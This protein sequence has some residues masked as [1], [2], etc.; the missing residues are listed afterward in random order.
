MVDIA[1]IK[2]V[3]SFKLIKN[4]GKTSQA[5]KDKLDAI[6]TKEAEQ[7]AKD[8]KKGKIDEKELKKKLDEIKKE[9]IRAELPKLNVNK[10]LKVIK[11]KPEE[12]K[13]QVKQTEKNTE[14]KKKDKP[15]QPKRKAPTLKEVREKNLKEKR[16]A[17]KPKRKP[18]QKKDTV[19]GKPP[20]VEK[21]KLIKYVEKNLDTS[22]SSKQQPKLIQ[23]IIEYFYKEAIDG[24][25]VK[26]NTYRKG[27]NLEFL[28]NYD[29]EAEGYKNIEDFR[30]LYKS[31]IIKNIK[32]NNLDID[33]LEESSN[34]DENEIIKIISSKEEPKKKEQAKQTEK[35]PEPETD[36]EDEDFVLPSFFKNTP[37]DIKKNILK[38]VDKGDLPSS[39]FVL[40][41]VYKTIRKIKNAVEK[42]DRGND[43]RIDGLGRGLSADSEDENY[44]KAIYNKKFPK[45]EI[46]KEFLSVA[47]NMIGGDRDTKMKARKW[48][49]KADVTIQKKLFNFNKEG[50]L[51]TVTGVNDK[52]GE[53]RKEADKVDRA[54]AREKAQREKEFQQAKREQA[55]EEEKIKK[56]KKAGEAV[57]K[58]V[59]RKK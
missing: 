32:K 5:D 39:S 43:E 50:Y 18:P 59:S 13:E 12:K 37:E 41:N 29:Q 52:T 40:V 16:E 53:K 31:E 3:S 33:G 28:A 8:F 49:D 54:I 27:T 6:Q 25:N 20:T 22:K 21:A 30:K 11:E 4:K 24:Q 35:K 36:T 42:K 56:Q 34:I 55:K 44:W 38:S 1:N 58:D 10:L 51:S 48:I 17:M 7:L 47:K 2:D 19:R 45:K 15:P 23:E 46:E 14:E 9:R 57:K 26:F